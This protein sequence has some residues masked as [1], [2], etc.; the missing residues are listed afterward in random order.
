MSRDIS[1]LTDSCAED[2]LLAGA[3]VNPES[4]DLA[5]AV[6]GENDFSDPGKGQMWSVFSAMQEAGMPFDVPMI[7]SQ[8][9][10]HGVDESLRSPAR[11]ASIIN[12]GT[13]NA[14]KVDFHA[15][16][17]KQ[18]S[19]KRQQ[20]AAYEEAAGRLEDLKTGPDDVS[21]WLEAKLN[22]IGVVEESLRVRIDDAAES[23]IDELSKPQQ[24][25]KIVMTGLL[26]HD[27]MVGGWLNGEL[28]IF[29]ARPG[30]GKTAF[31]MQICEHNAYLGRSCLYVSLEM[32]EQELVMRTLCGMAGVDPRVFRTGTQKQEHIDAVRKAKPV[33]DGMPLTLWSPSSATVQ[34]IR[35]ISK[36]EAAMNGLDLLVVDYLQLLDP[37]DPKAPRQEQVAKISRD[38]KQLARELNV[39]VLCLCQLNREADQEVPRLKHLRESGAIE[40]DAD[41]ATF[42][43]RDGPKSQLIV[44]KHRGHGTLGNLDIEWDHKRRRYVAP[45]LGMDEE[46]KEEIQGWDDWNGTG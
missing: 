36:Q 43:H 18:L 21:R 24:A 32:G 13:P 30:C 42:L 23:A 12:W 10:V 46:R 16:L 9:K 41:V 28:V 15:K 8:F 31:A 20:I 45:D 5:R 38:L 25:R 44:A 22:S 35:A 33:L 14:G 1:N 7:M 17:V 40:Q 26:N 29:A 2:A 34:Q 11:I 27:E 3:I 37:S 6:V 39:P 19:V 4:F